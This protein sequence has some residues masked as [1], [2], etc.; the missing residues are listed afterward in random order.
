MTPRANPL[1]ERV[2]PQAPG[3]GAGWW[4]MPSSEFRGLLAG[5]GRLG[6]DRRALLVS[7][8]VRQ[9][10]VDNPDAR[11]PCEALGKML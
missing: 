6:Y 9:A 1:T 3:S 5:L 4:G 2:T 11:I 7:A 10:D 8:G